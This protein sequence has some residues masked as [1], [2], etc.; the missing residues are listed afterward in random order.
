[1]WGSPAIRTTLTI[2]NE[3]LT[4]LPTDQLIFLDKGPLSSFAEPQMVDYSKEHGIQ[5]GERSTSI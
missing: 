5:L 1:M 3:G 4:I 2:C